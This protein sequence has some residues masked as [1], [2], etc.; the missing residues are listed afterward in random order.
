MLMPEQ[1]EGAARLM[2]GWGGLSEPGMGEEVG[3]DWH[4]V[5]TSEP[6]AGF[7][8]VSWVPM[9]NRQATQTEHLDH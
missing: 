5:L 8:P 4:G 2:S 9:R 7:Q 3:A 1:N 6:Q